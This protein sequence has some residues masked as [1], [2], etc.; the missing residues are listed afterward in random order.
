M[1]MT[2]NPIT[3]T[4][5]IDTLVGTAGADH[6]TGLDS[7]DWLR[8]REGADLIEG[9]GGIDS[10]QGGPGNDS[11]YGG[12]G[13]DMIMG[14]ADADVIYGG[15]DSDQIGGGTGWDTIY[16]DEGADMIGDGAGNDS[17]YGGADNDIIFSQEGSDRL[18]GGEGND[19]VFASHGSDKLYGN[20]GDDWLIG[21]IESTGYT[22][23]WG[24]SGRDMILAAGKGAAGA[25]GGADD[26]IVAA[27]TTLMSATLAGGAGQDHLG[28]LAV[29]DGLSYMLGAPT[30]DGDAPAPVRDDPDL[31]V[32]FSGG[33]GVAKADGRVFATFS[34]FELLAVSAGNGDDRI[35]GSDL[36]DYL[37]VGAGSNTVYGRG[38]DDMLSY[39]LGEKQVIDGGTGVDTVRILAADGTSLAL[40]WKDGSDGHGSVASNVEALDVA[41]GDRADVA[42]LSAW[43]DRFSGGDGNDLAWGRRGDDKLGGA[44][45]NDQLFGHENADWLFGG[46]GD[47]WMYGGTGGDTLAGE[48]GMDRL[49][50]G[51]GADVFVF[52]TEDSVA[53]WV[54]DF[55]TGIDELHISTGRIGHTLSAGALDAARFHADAAVGTAGQFVLLD[56]GILERLVWDSNG[57]NGGGTVQVALLMPG[58]G[59][60]AEDIFLI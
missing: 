29:D 4:P 55:Q 36:A 49:W 7:D 15:A 21:G 52:K 6:I 1:T 22:E 17:V 9:G 30:G 60:T 32:D 11:L 10:I 50:G 18:H 24:A 38:G 3:G 26:D 44:N 19:T 53:D 37:D 14:A 46:T 39:V 43:G 8:G 25:Y 33:S 23:F 20:G 58:S 54:K 45:G 57:T 47:D 59:V 27:S 5:D 12:A 28:L 48:A 42:K 16:G 56:E 31:W 35:H 41:G 2:L 51:D 13:A 34:G 40:N